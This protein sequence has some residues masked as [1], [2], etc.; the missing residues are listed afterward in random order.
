MNH[1]EVLLRHLL[2]PLQAVLDTP[3]VTEVVCNQ[4]GEIAI[5][6]YG[7]WEYL[8]IPELAFDH[9]DAIGVLAGHALSK[10]FGPAAPVCLAALPD[11]QRLTMCRPPVTENGTISMTT[12]IPSKGE[13]RLDDA[14]FQSLV[15][16]ANTVNAQS[17]QRDKRL[18]E[19]YRSGNWPSFLA[20][21][22]RSRKTI[23]VTGNTGSGK[24]SLIKR[25]MTS[26]PPEER[27]VTIQDTDE[28]GRISQI[29][30]YVPLYYGSANVS[31]LDLAEVSLRMRPTRVLMQEL[32]GA[33]AFAYLRILLAGHAGSCTTI[34]SE[35]GVEAARHAISVMVKTHPAGRE[36]PDRQ[37]DQLLG[38]LIDVVVHCTRDGDEFSIPYIW[39]RDA[40]DDR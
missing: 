8:P 3:G 38:N 19:L 7:A 31:A 5:E 18:L 10:P 4:P 39:Y 40:G 21:A 25:M 17:V 37:L 13:R 22:V 30:N 1:G 20:E 23:V 28:F 35:M 11:G 24:T 9:L 36:I 26:I 34:H 29:R 6:R 27:I 33:E 2:A 32:R 14:D 16:Y 15:T 12:R